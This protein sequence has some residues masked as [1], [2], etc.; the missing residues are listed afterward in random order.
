MIAANFKLNQPDY[1]GQ[2]T[3]AGVRRWNNLFE[4]G[5]ENLAGL[6]NASFPSGFDKP[7]GLSRITP[8]YLWFW[9]SLRLRVRAWLSCHIAS[10]TE[11]VR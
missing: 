2:L 11:A 4:G 1:W 3:F 6:I 5:F 7:L 8:V 9:P 10:Q